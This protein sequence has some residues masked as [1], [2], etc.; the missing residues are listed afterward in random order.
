M[1]TI[2]RFSRDGV[3]GEGQFSLRVTD[4]DFN[5]LATTPLALCN[6]GGARPEGEEIPSYC[7]A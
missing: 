7:S 5:V 1:W 2:G 3:G 6:N 4:T